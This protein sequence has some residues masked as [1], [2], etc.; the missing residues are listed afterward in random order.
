M[1]G[2]TT[3][4]RLS[5]ELRERLERTASRLHRGKSWL[6]TRALEE[7]LARRESGELREEARRQS[8]L[9]SAAAWADETH[10]ESDVD[11]R[12]WQA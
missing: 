3:S 1:V 9:A 10:W 6:I 2:V 5:P 7:Y 8:E 11:E 4:I 12:G